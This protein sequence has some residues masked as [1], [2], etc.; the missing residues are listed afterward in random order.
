MGEVLQT[1]RFHL[2]SIGVGQTSMGAE[3]FDSQS[4]MR[5]CAAIDNNVGR[6]YTGYKGDT[7]WGHA[8]GTFEAWVKDL[9]K[10]LG[11]LSRKK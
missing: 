2:S 4:E 9:R 8:E 3:I 1:F 7:K 6:N 10:L 5:S 11:K